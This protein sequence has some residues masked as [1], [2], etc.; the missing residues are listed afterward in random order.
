[1]KGLLISLRKEQGTLLSFTIG[2]ASAHKTTRV[3]LEEKKE[4]GVS[5]NQRQRSIG[6]LQRRDR[7]GMD[8][9]PEGL[10]R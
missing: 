4:L 9:G 3:D 1:M 5:K 6:L 8:F 2:R 10:G 7:G